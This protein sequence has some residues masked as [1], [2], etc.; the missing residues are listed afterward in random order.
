MIMLVQF[1]IY[2]SQARAENYVNLAEE[3]RIMKRATE[4][5]VVQLRRYS[6]PLDQ[7]SKT[8]FIIL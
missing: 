7:Q 3:S 1:N 4:Q 2:L 5:E 8:T 6:Q